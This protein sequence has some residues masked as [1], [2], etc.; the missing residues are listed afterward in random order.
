MLV[1]G[2]TMLSGKFA[3]VSSMSIDRWLCTYQQTTDR[4]TESDAY[5]PTVQSAQM[6]LK[7]AK[8]EVFGM[9]EYFGSQIIK[10]DSQ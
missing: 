4:Q 7:T 3:I 5:E 2:K 9:K 10:E 8:N 6:G 1:Q